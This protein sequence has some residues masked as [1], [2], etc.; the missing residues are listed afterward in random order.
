MK[1]NKENNILDENSP[2]ENE[3][4][5]NNTY[6]SLTDYM[7]DKNIEELGNEKNDNNLKKEKAKKKE[8][9]KKK[10]IIYKEFKKLKFTI[11]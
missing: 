7:K 10:N 8:K 4:E 11:L 3:K 5:N 1:Q 9:E 2:F 6:N